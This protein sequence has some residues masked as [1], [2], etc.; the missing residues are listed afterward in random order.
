MGERTSAER[1]SSERSSCERSCSRRRRPSFSESEDI[2]MRRSNSF[3]DGE[4]N[5]RFF[6]SRCDATSAFRDRNHPSFSKRHRLTSNSDWTNFHRWRSGQLRIAQALTPHQPVP[7]SND[8]TDLSASYPPSST[9]RILLI[10]PTV[11]SMDLHEPGHHLTRTTSVRPLPTS[12]DRRDLEMDCRIEREAAAASHCHGER[13]PRRQLEQRPRRCHEDTDPGV[14]GRAG[15]SS[16][17]ESASGGNPCGQIR[18]AAESPPARA[19]HG[20][21][22]SAAALRYSDVGL[23]VGL[24]SPPP[25]PASGGPAASAA[26]SAVDDSDDT[27]AL[28]LKYTHVVGPS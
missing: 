7:S 6:L 12:S 19:A 5:V 18:H 21:A 23:L 8:P 22:M 27:L 9:S 28:L 24:C 26:A 25:Q 11:S 14:G 13:P 1:M 3:S 2:R 10:S 20:A 17:R 4:E 16:R 15:D